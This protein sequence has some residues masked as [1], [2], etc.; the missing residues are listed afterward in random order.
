MKIF[1]FFKINLKIFMI[2]TN[3]CE[4]YGIP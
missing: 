1:K 2:I 4:H 3:L